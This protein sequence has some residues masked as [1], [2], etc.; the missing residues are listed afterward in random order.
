MSLLGS[1]P[2]K[3]KSPIDYHEKKLENPFYKRRE[4]MVSF[5]GLKGKLTI[6]ATALVFI[7]VFWFIF[8][9]HF[10]GITKISISGLDQM[11]NDDIRSL[12]TE[13]MHSSNFILFPQGNLLF[14]SEKKFQNTLQKKYHF[15][16]IIIKKEWPNSLSINII[17]KPLACIWSENNKY[18]YTD[19]DGYIV[20]EINSLDIKDAKY[21]LI[22][23]QSTLQMYNNRITVDPSYISFVSSLYDKFTEVMPSIKID[24]FIIDNDVDTIKLLTTGGLELIF[25]TKDDAN[26]Q[27]NNLLILKNQKLK[28]SFD[29]QKMIDLRF[30]DKIYYQ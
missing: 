20:Q 9:S 1:Y 30:G 17:S 22:T 18:F 27:L 23:N 13:Q 4:R 14:F 28:D 24:H 19:T 6:I 10:W 7:L 25:N 15:Q 8:I 12:I 11:S 3:K 26:K 2:A 29:K 16:K 5:A 21:P